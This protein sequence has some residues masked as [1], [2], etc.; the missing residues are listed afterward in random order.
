MGLDIKDECDK[1]INDLEKEHPIL[2]MVSFNDMNIQ[3][4]LMENS[5]LSAQYMSLLSAE[6]REYEILE[7]KYDAL[8]G[9]RFDHYR[10]NTDKELTK[11]EIEKYYLPQDKQI[12]Q[13]KKILMKQKTRVE[14]FDA[15]V[16]G[17]KQVQWNMKTF[18]E[19]ARR[20]M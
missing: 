19:N 16:K 15:C 6:Q 9:L 13:M 11:P 10:F 7:E 1:I 2:E 5:Y 20:N 8:V 14:F 17:L 4:K 12:R 18:S 3:E